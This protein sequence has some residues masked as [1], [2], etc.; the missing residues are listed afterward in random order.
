MKNG[1]EKMVRIQELMQELQ[2][3]LETLPAYETELHG[4]LTELDK[5]TV[6]ILHIAENIEMSGDEKILLVDRTHE[7]REERREIKYLLSVVTPI[8]KVTYNLA[9]K[10]S[11][12]NREISSVLKSS[13]PGMSY[14]FR[15]R[16]G[17][18][19]LKRIVPDYAERS[20]IY[21][22]APNL[23]MANEER[24]STFTREAKVVTATAPV[25]SAPVE[26][27]A[28]VKVEIA[29]LKESDKSYQI[30]R[31][32]NMWTLRDGL[33]V[34]LETLDLK[35]LIEYLF[36]NGW[37]FVS[38]DNSSKAQLKRDLRESKKEVQDDTNRFVHCSRLQQRLF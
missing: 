20:P 26:A 33:T 11:E 25:A 15:S 4:K 9:P 14:N 6:D 5:E 22:N 23:P 27:P 13:N 28:P 7:L 21:L 34:V 32:C 18:D 31:V 3:E 35:E 1:Y 38:T 8:S 2:T 12:K 10:L 29:P 17:F 36:V 37:Q 30:V 19:L 16:S 24:F